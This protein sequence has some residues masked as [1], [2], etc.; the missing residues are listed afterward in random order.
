M[1][2][3]DLF[4]STLAEE[5]RKAGVP[6]TSPTEREV[7]AQAEKVLEEMGFQFEHGKTWMRVPGGYPNTSPAEVH[8]RVGIPE[9]D[10][11]FP[12]DS[13]GIITAEGVDGFSETAD[14]GEYLAMDTA[15][16]HWQ[17][18]LAGTL[19]KCGLEVRIAIFDPSPD[20][21]D[22]PGAMYLEAVIVKGREGGLEAFLATKLTSAEVEHNQPRYTLD[23]LKGRIDRA[24][25]VEF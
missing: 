2:R 24:K 20:D 17:R 21:F 11:V 22:A 1:D 7:R 10:R 23:E 13:A 14:L 19:C 3:K 25:P 4:K 8:L 5:A 9:A 6:G 15:A 18:A 16:D 12:V